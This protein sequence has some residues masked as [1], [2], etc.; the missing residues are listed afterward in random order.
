[1]NVIVRRLQLLAGLTALL[2]VSSGSA[3]AATLPVGF[4]E[5]LIASASAERRAASA[6]RLPRAGSPTLRLLLIKIPHLIAKAVPG[7]TTEAA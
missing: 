7:V 4:S 1:M 2:L 5:T 6:A 3:A